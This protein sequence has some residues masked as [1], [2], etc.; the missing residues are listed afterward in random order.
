MSPKPWPPETFCF[1]VRRARYLLV[2]RSPGSWKVKWTEE[3][4]SL[5]EP[6]E[7]LTDTNYY[8]DC[9]ESSWVIWGLNQPE[10]WWPFFWPQHTLT[11]RIVYSEMPEAA[12]PANLGLFQLVIT[13]DNNTTSFHRSITDGLFSHGPILFGHMHHR[14]KV[15]KRRQLS[16]SLFSAFP[17]R[18][19]LMAVNLLIFIPKSFSLSK[20]CSLCCR[21]KTYLS[22]WVE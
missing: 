14:C 20:P 16:C 5:A 21:M 3:Q 13:F 15:T 9:V 18:N 11:D 8:M 1:P 22:G 17:R 7:S 4:L 10:Q 6:A 2:P 12:H 19:K